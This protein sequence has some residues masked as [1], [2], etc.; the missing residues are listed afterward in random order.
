MN[1]EPE[2]YVPIPTHVQSLAVVT[3]PLPLPRLNRMM[4]IFIDAADI[5]L[6]QYIPAI[7][8]SRMLILQLVAVMQMKELEIVAWTFVF[9][10]ALYGEPQS[11]MITGL[12]F[13]AYL[14]KSLLCNDMKEVEDAVQRRW[15]NFKPAYEFWLARHPRCTD[16]NLHDL[17]Q[18][19]KS[20]WTLEHKPSVA[21]SLNTVVDDIVQV[22][23]APTEEE[24]CLR[25][26]G[27]ETQ[28]SGLMESMETVNTQSGLVGEVQVTTEQEELF[29]R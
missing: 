24:K 23:S 29:T 6:K 25:E 5:Q 12:Q 9:R 14:A 19:F 26:Q 28:G 15:L 8:G 17:H 18:Q 13:S 21:V 16:I 4:E 7:T 22:A 10:R 3:E 2:I 20:M 27:R 1:R 11:M